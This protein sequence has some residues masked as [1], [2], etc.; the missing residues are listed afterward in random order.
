MNLTIALFTEMNQINDQTKNVFELSGS[1]IFREKLL[2]L[3]RT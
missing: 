1:K 3:K 2:K